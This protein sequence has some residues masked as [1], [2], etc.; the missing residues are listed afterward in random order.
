MT[1]F[2]G[3]ILNPRVTCILGQ[4]EYVVAPTILN[5]Q[6]FYFFLESNTSNFGWVYTKINQHLQDQSNFCRSHREYVLTV[7][8]LFMIKVIKKEKFDKSAAVTCNF[9]GT[10]GRK[11]IWLL[12]SI[13]C[14]Q[15]RCIGTCN[16]SQ[17][18]PSTLQTT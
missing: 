15:C 7:H 1:C 2:L 3:Q 8:L 11:C 16:V 5:I 9:A 6:L 12:W 13:A 10:G 4:R 17:H 18:L 14:F